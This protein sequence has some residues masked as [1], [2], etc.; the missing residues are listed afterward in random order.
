[1]TTRT[2]FDRVFGKTPPPSILVTGP[3][4]SGTRIAAKMVAADLGYR[5]FDEQTIGVDAFDVAIG[6][7]EIPQVV[8]HAPGICHLTHLMWDTNLCPPRVAVLI[9]L[10]DLEEIQ[11]SCARINWFPKAEEQKYLSRP[12]FAPYLAEGAHV[13]QWKYDVWKY[14]Q[15]PLMQTLIGDFYYTIKYEDMSYH[16]LWIPAEERRGFKWNQTERTHDER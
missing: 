1:M 6:I 15:R 13:A 11:R 12:E 10:R 3:Q 16:P 2:I 9:V 7:L 8:L 14:Y 4:R 5:Y